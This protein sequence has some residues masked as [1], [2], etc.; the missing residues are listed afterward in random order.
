MNRMSD[1]PKG[2][3]PADVVPR[4]R[5]P[6]WKI[7]LAYLVM[8]TVAILSIWLID[9]HVMKVSKEAARAEGF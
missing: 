5:W 7:A 2:V 6:R 8:L 9:T 3:A 1:T 4:P